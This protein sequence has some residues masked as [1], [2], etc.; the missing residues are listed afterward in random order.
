MGTIPTIPTYTAGQVLTAAELNNMK[1][2]H[3]F[4]ALTPRCSVYS[5]GAQ[6]IPNST[7]TLIAF[8]T[9]VYDIVMAGDGTSHSNVTNN[10]RIWFRT[11][12]KYEIA[13]QLQFATSGTGARDAQIRLNSGGSSA[14]GTLVTINQQTAVAS[15]ST[16]VGIVTFE[17]TFNDGDYIEMFGRQNSGGALNTV[18]GYGITFMRIKLTG[19]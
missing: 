7:Y 9:E 16:S 12:G 1:A 8:D 15:G 5:A 17:D 13:A 4:W 2:V 10:S 18:P 19:S 11:T 6:S 14:G 3:D